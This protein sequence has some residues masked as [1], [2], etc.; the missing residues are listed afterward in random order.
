M[1][2]DEVSCDNRGISRNR[3]YAKVWERIVLRGELIHRPRVSIRSFMG[4]TGLV[5]T[6]WTEGT[7]NRLRLTTHQGIMNGAR[8]PMRVS[9]ENLDFNC[10]F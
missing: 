9:V 2:L 8:I 6:F 1:F 4:Q 7:F 10:L 3:G 5:E